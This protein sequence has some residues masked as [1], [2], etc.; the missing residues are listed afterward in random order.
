M[1]IRAQE[2]F[3]L[4]CCGPAKNNSV[5][6]D[7]VSTADRLTLKQDAWWLIVSENSGEC[8]DDTAEMDEQWGGRTQCDTSVMT[9]AIIRSTYKRLMKRRK[10]SIHCHE[11]MPISLNI[12]Q[13]AWKIWGEDGDDVPFRIIPCTTSLPWRTSAWATHDDSCSA[14][15]TDAK[16]GTLYRM[17]CQG[18]TIRASGHLIFLDCTTNQQQQESFLQRCNKDLKMFP[19]PRNICCM[20]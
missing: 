18:M 3:A 20:I 9:G 6:S 17:L 16:W 12:Q 19:P 11:H 8:A 10:K 15:T 7:S 5:M 13:A 14:P 4:R 2:N 1:A